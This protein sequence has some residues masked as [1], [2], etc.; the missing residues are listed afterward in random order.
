[1]DGM[2]SFDTNVVGFRKVYYETVLPQIAVGPRALPT[3]QIIACDDDSF[4]DD[5]IPQR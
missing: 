4:D 5:E 2:S 3:A 1:M